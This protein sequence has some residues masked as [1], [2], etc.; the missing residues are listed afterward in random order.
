MAIVDVANTIANIEGYNVSGSLAQRNNNPGNLIYVGQAGATQGQGGFAAFATPDAGFAALQAQ[1]S[2][3][4]SR[5]ETVSQFI[6]KYDPVPSETNNYI[7]LFT[8]QL[9]V[10]PNDL[11]SDVI[12]G[13]TSTNVASDS[14]SSPSLDLSSMFSNI[15][16]TDP[17]TLGIGVAIII[18]VVFLS[19]A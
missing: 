14:S 6:T 19:R 17:T 10:G 8:S 13:N 2:L 16:L 15:D 18:A 5:G 12:A 11:L 4:A 7:N 9:G 3:D 1:I